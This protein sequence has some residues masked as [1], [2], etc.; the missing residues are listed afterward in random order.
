MSHIDQRISAAVQAERGR[1]LG[2]VKHPAAA[3]RMNAALELARLPSMT[4]EAAGAV[5]GSLPKETPRGIAGEFAAFLD[6]R[7]ITATD[8][9]GEDLDAL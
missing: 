5:L 6:R 1:I 3:G 2:I 7:G 4:P 8:L 9:K